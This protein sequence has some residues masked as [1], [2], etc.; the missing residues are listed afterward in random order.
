MQYPP[1]SHIRAVCTIRLIVVATDAYVQVIH[2]LFNNDH[3]VH[4]LVHTFS[5]ETRSPMDRPSLKPNMLPNMTLNAFHF[6]LLLL[7]MDTIC[8]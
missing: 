6:Y 7:C 8:V 3:K 4:V 2:I 1:V 5:F